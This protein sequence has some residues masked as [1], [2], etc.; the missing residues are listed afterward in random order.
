MCW[1]FHY[2]SMNMYLSQQ[3]SL[4]TWI[5][6]VTAFRR[7]YKRKR[8]QHFCL[9]LDNTHIGHTQFAM[10]RKG[11]CR[12]PCVMIS[13]QMT[14]WF[15]ARVTQ[16]QRRPARTHSRLLSP[17]TLWM[18]NILR[19]PC[20]QIRVPPVAPAFCLGRSSTMRKLTAFWEPGIIRRCTTH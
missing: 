12:K 13:F 9:N 1:E 17:D 3:L 5:L 18:V 11:N 16:T 7:T 8:P 15:W 6:K 14:P 19:L 10:C 4:Y 20:V 2:F